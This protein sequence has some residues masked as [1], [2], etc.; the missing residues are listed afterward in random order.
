M[1]TYLYN[2]K[3][4]RSAALSL[5]FSSNLLFYTIFVFFELSYSNG[6]LTFS[7]ICVFFMTIF[8]FWFLL[9][10]KSKMELISISK[11]KLK[12]PS[13][14][15][16]KSSKVFSIS[17]IDSVQDLP[18]DKGLVINLIGKFPI[19]ISKDIFETADEYR[20][21]KNTLKKSLTLQ[22]KNSPEYQASNALAAQQIGNFDV[23]TLLIITTLLIFFA[24]PILFFGNE[25]LAN[26][27]LL[28][29]NT[30]TLF[31]ENELYR[32]FSSTLLHANFLHLM[33]NILVLTIYARALEKILGAVRFIN[34]Y[35]ISGI[36]GA[37]FS[38][39][40]SPFETS[41][42]ASGCIYGL[43]GAFAFLRTAF[44]KHLPP[45]I[46][47][48]PAWF[49]LLIFCFEIGMSILVSNID[50][51]S[52][53]AGFFT[54]FFYTWLIPKGL[55]LRKLRDYV[56]L[57]KYILI[58]FTAAYLLSVAYFMRMVIMEW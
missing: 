6:S 35:L 4:T 53:A 15:F 10:R 50:F 44:S 11:F 33:L 13:P 21:F 57:E 55:H 40:F 41:I 47:M 8:S 9:K 17:L 46:K 24:S 42:G 54:G 19:Y 58:F 14:Y 49:F 23:L 22:V 5:F 16:W 28:G 32:L 30:K 45:T 2:S 34:V 25:Y 7:L 56:T 20:E 3:T 36:V 48:A 52:H 51:Y 31:E 27:I 12:I 26:A 43:I 29:G 18:R 39:L 38:N 1:N 37:L